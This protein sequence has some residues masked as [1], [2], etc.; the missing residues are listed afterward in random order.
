MHKTPCSKNIV[1]FPKNAPFLSKTAISSQWKLQSLCKESCA[2]LSLSLRSSTSLDRWPYLGAMSDPCCMMDPQL[3]QKQ[4]CS[5]SV[6]ST[7]VGSSTHGVGLSHS[8][9]AILKCSPPGHRAVILRSYSRK[10]GT[11]AGFKHCYHIT[12]GFLFFFLQIL[13]PPKLS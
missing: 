13:Y 12:C 10:G 3:C 4:L 11:R 1:T 8:L 7:S 5:V 2:P 6:F 9:R